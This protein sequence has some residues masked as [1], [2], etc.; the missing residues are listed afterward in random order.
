MADW[1]FNEALAV[2]N[3]LPSIPTSVLETPDGLRLG[4]ICFAK[5]CTTIQMQAMSLTTLEKLVS[6]GSFNPERIA[7]RDHS[8]S[9]AILL[10][11]SPDAQLKHVESVGIGLVVHWHGALLAPISSMAKFISYIHKMMK[12]E[13][14]SAT[15]KIRTYCMIV[16]NY[17]GHMAYATE[18][19]FCVAYLL[20]FVKKHPSTMT[21]RNTDNH[22][23][24]FMGMDMIV[25]QLLA[26][27]CP[28]HKYV[29]AS[30]NSC[31]IIP[32]GMPFGKELL[33]EIV[34]PWNHAAPYHDPDTG[35]EAPFITVGP[36]CSTDTLFP[37]SAR[38]LQLYTTKEVVCLMNMGVLKPS[39]ALA[40]P[41][42]CCHH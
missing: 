10:A 24:M 18:L 23:V 13:R 40:F 36:I 34:I 41:F 29:R 3:S 6:N 39:S 26:Q 37:G 8:H 25:C 12:L 9:T 17:G 1:T 15:P 2:I 22:P 42:L 16:G 7:D 33:P 11:L 28:E 19:P 38:D 35:K 5:I 14:R 4:D 31:L 21:F 30:H 32:R 27:D 20:D